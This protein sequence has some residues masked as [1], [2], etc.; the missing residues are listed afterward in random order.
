VLDFNWKAMNFTTP[1]E[2]HVAVGRP[3]IHTLRTE[4]NLDTICRR[5]ASGE[6]LTTILETEGLPSYAEFFRWMAADEV[7]R[8]NYVRARTEQGHW[9]AD[10]IAQLAMQAP[11]IGEHGVDAAEVAHRRLAIDALKW[12]AAKRTPKSYGD[13]QPSGTTVNVGVQVA[14]VLTEEERAEL[15]AA[16]Q[17][18]IARQ[19]AQQASLPA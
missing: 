1:A 18:S 4:E 8:D 14:G 5:I 11:N 16:K 10:R 3:S 6:A 15:M 19:R 13:D 9:Y 17:R 7:A 12:L 2:A